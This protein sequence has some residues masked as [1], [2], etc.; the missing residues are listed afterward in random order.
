MVLSPVLS[1]ISPGLFPPSH[2]DIFRASCKGVVLPLNVLE[3]LGRQILVRQ[4]TSG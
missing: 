1:N 3:N 2:L 4:M